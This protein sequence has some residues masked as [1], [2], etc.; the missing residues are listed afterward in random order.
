MADAV[1]SRLG[2]I[3]GAGDARALFLKVF[4]NEILSTFQETNVMMPL[5]R[6]KTITSGKT[7]QFPAIGT[8]DADYHVPGEEISGGEIKHNERLIHID[9]ALLASTFIA[10]IDEAMNHYDVRSD[11]SQKLARALSLRC[12][13]NILQTAV[14][15][16]RASAT[17][18]GGQ[19]GTELT[20]ADYD[21][22]GATLAGGIF[23]AAQNLD[24]NDVPD[25]DDRYCVVKPAQYYNLVQTT[26]VINKDWDG[27]GSY[28]DG[29][30][31]KVANVTLVKSNNLPQSVIA[32]N[33]GENNT[34]SGTFTNTYAS[35]FHTSAMGTVKL[36]DLTTDSDFQVNRR[37]TLMLAEYFM[38]HGILRPEAAVEL[39]VA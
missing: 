15:A 4:A 31:L 30:V 26:N 10:N 38:G 16:A 3:N 32:S 19:G 25:M 18:T 28:A 9:S 12:D 8:I 13:K 20:D 5:H 35:V 39:N 27:K 11:Y 21:T 34:Y 14:L 29:K 7:A 1:P 36:K 23:D 6:V 17:I 37:G 33:T 2:Q 22:D 24:E